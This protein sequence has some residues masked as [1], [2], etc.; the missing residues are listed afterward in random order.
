MLRLATRKSCRIEMIDKLAL[1]Y[2]LLSPDGLTPRGIGR[3]VAKAVG[4][5]T[6]MD[7]EIRYGHL[8]DPGDDDSARFINQ[9]APLY[10][11]LND[12]SLRLV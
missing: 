2:V 4:R 5:L 6:A 1:A 11:A 3:L 8:F 9:H 12:D 7:T 10:N